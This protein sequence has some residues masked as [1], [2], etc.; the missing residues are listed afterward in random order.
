MSMGKSSHSNQDI[1]HPEVP[2]EFRQGLGHSCENYSGLVPGMPSRNPA[3][4]P[5][6]ST[7]RFS[8]R[9]RKGNTSD[10]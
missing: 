5:A 3:T 9:F 4:F 8:H 10:I 6:A 7:H 2:A 1:P